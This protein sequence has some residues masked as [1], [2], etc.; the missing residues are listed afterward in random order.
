MDDSKSWQTIST[1]NVL[2]EKRIEGFS[3]VSFDSMLEIYLNR[4]DNVSHVCG[5]VHSWIQLI[6]QHLIKCKV[7]HWTPFNEPDLYKVLDLSLIH[8]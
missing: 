8:I 3:S 1:W 4:V 2:Y 5:E 6:N 7:L